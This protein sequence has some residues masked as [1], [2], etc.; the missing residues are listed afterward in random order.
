[1]NLRSN[2]AKDNRSGLRMKVECLAAEAV[3]LIGLVKVGFVRPSGPWL[4]T[5]APV[6]GERGSAGYEDHGESETDYP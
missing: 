4:Q 3:E 5:D 1:M 2:K 6:Q